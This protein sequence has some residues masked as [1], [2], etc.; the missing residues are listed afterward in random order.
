M[1]VL[2]DFCWNPVVALLCRRQLLLLFEQA[3]DANSAKVRGRS[4]YQRSLAR[5]LVE[6]RA[7]DM[8]LVPGVLGSS[9]GYRR[10]RAIESGSASAL[11]RFTATVTIVAAGLVAVSVNAQSATHASGS[12]ERTTTRRILWAST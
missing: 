12:G 5:L 3:C 11:C 1:N 10:I 9:S 6:A 4:D 7:D 8:T 2:T